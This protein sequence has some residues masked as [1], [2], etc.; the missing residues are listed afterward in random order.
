MRGNLRLEAQNVTAA[1]MRRENSRSTADVLGWALPALRMARSSANARPLTA[2]RGFIS[3]VCEMRALGV[4]FWGWLA[5]YAGSRNGGDS[6]KIMVFEK[7]YYRS[8][9]TP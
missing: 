3:H 5:E 4:G 7:D 2:G 9:A 8:P 6:P 1:K